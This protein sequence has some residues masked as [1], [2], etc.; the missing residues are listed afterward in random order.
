MLGLSG[1]TGSQFKS[2][3]HLE[4]EGQSGRVD[5]KDFTTNTFV[6]GV[7]LRV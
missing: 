5:G 2:L 6:T 4:D 1:S 7:L 3:L